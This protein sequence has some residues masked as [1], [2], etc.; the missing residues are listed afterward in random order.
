MDNRLS[1]RALFRTGVGLLGLSLPHFLRLKRQVQ[2]AASPDRS[3]GQARSCIV[4][5]CWGGMSQLETWD[6]K[7]DAPR[8]IRGDYR[9]IATATPGIRLGEYMPLL[10]RQTGRLAIVRSMHH[11][12]TA[13]GKAM[14]WNVTGHPPPD[15][16]VVAN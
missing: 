9:P 5:F 14:Y 7:P 3:F 11:R 12:T 1:R 15:P 13:H 16:E 8:E 2:A 10:A 6:P 4:L